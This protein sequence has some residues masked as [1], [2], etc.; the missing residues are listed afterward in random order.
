LYLAIAVPP[1][2]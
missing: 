1:L 2:P